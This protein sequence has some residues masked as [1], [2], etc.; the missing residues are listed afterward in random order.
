[1][2]NQA[3]QSL[4]TSFGCTLEVAQNV[5]ASCNGNMEQADQIMM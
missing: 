4:M 3:A 2:S 1:M 5:L